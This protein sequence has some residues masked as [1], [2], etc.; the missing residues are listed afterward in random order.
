MKRLGEVTLRGMEVTVM[1]G[2]EGVP[3]KKK[4]KK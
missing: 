4:K 2:M 3:P 1:R